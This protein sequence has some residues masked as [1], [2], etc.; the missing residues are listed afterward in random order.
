MLQMLTASAVAAGSS[1]AVSAAA[2]AAPSSGAM[3]NAFVGVPAIAA[4]ILGGLALLA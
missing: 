2:S 3:S 4:G 1:A